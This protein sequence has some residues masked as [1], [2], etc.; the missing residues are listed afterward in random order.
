MIQY[1]AKPDLKLLII[2]FSGRVTKEE[3]ERGV[4]TAAKSLTALARKFR[5]L[6]DLTTLCSM[7]VECAPFIERVMDLCQEHGVA[8][9]IRIIP[10]P[11]QDIGLQIMSR[12]HYGSDV[13]IFTCSTHEEAFNLLSTGSDIDPAA[14]RAA[15]A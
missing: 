6:A 9:V 12:F 3:A 10:D 4:D 8:E 1:D 13:R 7:D 15:L 14:L 2:R 5:L 11:T